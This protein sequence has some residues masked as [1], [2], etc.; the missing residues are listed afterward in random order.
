MDHETRLKRLHFRAWHRGT[1]EAD[2]MIGGFFD[3]YGKSWSEPELNWFENLLAEDDVD[4]MAWAIG[5]Q[6][7]PEAFEGPQMAAMQKLDFIDTAK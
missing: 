4:V 5:T 3:R 7:V 2:F 1:R 6:I